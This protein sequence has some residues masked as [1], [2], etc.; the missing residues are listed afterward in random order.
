MARIIRNEF[1]PKITL[2]INTIMDGDNIITR[3]I[4]VGDVVENLRYVLNGEI[5]T[6]TGKVVAINFKNKNVKRSYVDITRL[7]SY[8]AEDVIAESIV[9][10]AS[11]QYASNVVTIPCREIIE[12]V[13]QENVVRMRY[14]LSY[15]VAAHVFLSDD[16]ENSY[17]IAEG[18]DVI[19]M[20]YLYRGTEPTVNARYVATIYDEYLNPVQYVFNCN[21][22]VLKI[23]AIAVKSIEKVI[24]PASD[25]NA[26]ND[27]I[28]AA[29]NGVVSLANGNFEEEVVVNKQVAI[30][31]NMMGVSA[32]NIQMRNTSK[33]ENET[34]I[35]APISAS[36]KDINIDIDGVTFKDKMTLNLPTVGDVSLKN[37]RMLKLDPIAAKE[38]PIRTYSDCPGKL[39]VRGCYFGRNN[40]DTDTNKVY[41]LFELN[42]P[43]KDG[44]VIEWNYF[45]KG[46]CGHNDINIYDVEDGAT[47]T[48]KNNSWEMSANAIRIGIKGDKHCTINIKDNVYYGTDE[49]YPDYAGLVL[50]QPYAKQ[51]TSMEHITINIDGTVHKDDHQIFYLYAGPGDMQFDEYNVPTINVDGVCVLA[52]KPRNT[53]DLEELDDDI[54][55]SDA[56]A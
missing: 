52:P 44:S 10:D 35:T 55:V 42:G 25:D 54:I 17:E 36:S 2:H 39:T 3:I 43:L 47:I 5:Q 20:T 19:G 15:S 40:E 11:E 56:N 29:E 32:I 31:G 4:N 34:I 27:L 6:I 13:D 1:K 49:E 24:S 38:Y 16:L 8:F 41:N 7:R 50:I 51:T 18:D 21:E 14:F 33:E 28:A 53:Q 22:K 37:C 48:I 45:E 23:D 46:A 9:V 30:Q 12:D 26:I